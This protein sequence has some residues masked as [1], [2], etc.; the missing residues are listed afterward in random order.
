MS[1]F[2]PGM[3]TSSSPGAGNA[4][5]VSTPAL[6]ADEASNWLTEDGSNWLTEDGSL[7][8]LDE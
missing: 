7:W 4:G 6:P 5:G 8:L 1:S 2:G 3:H